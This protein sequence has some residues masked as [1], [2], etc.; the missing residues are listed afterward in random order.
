M[1]DHGL[2]TPVYRQ[3]AAILRDRIG[4]GELVAGDRIPSEHEMVAAHGIARTTARRAVSVLRDEGLVYSVPGQGVFVGS[5]EAS[6][7]RGP[8]RLPPYRRIAVD[9]I[10]RVR[11]GEWPPGRVLPSEQHLMAE[12]DVAKE[13]V[14]RAVAVARDA[15]WLYTVPRRGTYVSP[16]ERWPQD[17]SADEAGRGAQ[18]PGPS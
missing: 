15:G 4:S 17:V 18:S 14:R 11:A 7:P 10:A 16:R 6:A 8:A 9:L 3:L 5:D 12:Y 13:T 2:S 1:L